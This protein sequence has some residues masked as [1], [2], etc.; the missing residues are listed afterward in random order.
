MTQ[1]VGEAGCPQAQIA[2]LA[3]DLRSCLARRY[4]CAHPP[5]TNRELQVTASAQQRPAIVS[6]VRKRPRI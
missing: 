4:S 5:T 6:Q 2:A 1:E 3:R